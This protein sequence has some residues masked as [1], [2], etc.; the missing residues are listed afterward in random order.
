MELHKSR[1]RV[2]KRLLKFFYE[3][4]DKLKG[5]DA[6]EWTELHFLLKWTWTWTELYLKIKWTELEYFPQMNLRLQWISMLL[7]FF[8]CIWI[9]INQIFTYKFNSSS[10]C[11]FFF[12]MLLT[13]RI[14]SYLFKFK[15]PKINLKCGVRDK[16]VE[17]EILS[18]LKVKLKFINKLRTNVKKIY[19]PKWI[20][21]FFSFW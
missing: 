4:W 19:F 5:K 1:F 9:Q 7:I 15:W 17:I 6:V 12:L 21:L 11:Q 14:S 8:C 16:M 2:N 10:L 13:S 3:F 20:E 18:E